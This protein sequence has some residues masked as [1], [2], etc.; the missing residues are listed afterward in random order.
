MMKTS[1]RMRRY[2]LQLADSWGLHAIWSSTMRH[3]YN[4]NLVYLHPVSRLE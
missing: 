3:L 4:A 2:T 1:E